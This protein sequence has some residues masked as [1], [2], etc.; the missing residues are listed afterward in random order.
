MTRRNLNLE[1][2]LDVDWRNWAQ[3]ENNETISKKMIQKYNLKEVEP[4]KTRGGKKEE[5][6]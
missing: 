3:E 1:Q 5:K 6:N 4:E 2:K